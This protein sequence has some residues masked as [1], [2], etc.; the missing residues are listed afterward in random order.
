MMRFLMLWR[1]YSLIFYLVKIYKIGEKEM[2]KLLSL[3]LVALMLTLSIFVVSC[4][5][6]NGGG[7]GEMIYTEDTTLGTGNTQFTLII[8]HV[9]DKKV[10]FTINTD[11]AILSD[12]L[13]E[14]GLLVG[15][16]DT[17]GLYIDTVNGVTHDYNTDQT[18][19]A[20]YEGD[21]YALTGV[22]GITI[23]N[24]ATYKLV[25]SR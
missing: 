3:T 6:R 2:K 8:E 20:I 17:Y 23:V 24:G 11:K 1:V 15:H 10:T 21:N 13:V 5:D 9:N 12:A 16:D 22:D 18:Y 14:I 4:V 7:S 19:W 25:A